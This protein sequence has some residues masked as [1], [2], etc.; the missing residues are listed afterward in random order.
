MRSERSRSEL[1]SETRNQKSES[2]L[3][4]SNRMRAKLETKDQKLRSE[5]RDRRK[6]KP[7]SETKNRKSESGLEPEDRTKARPTIRN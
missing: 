4:P 6:P 3:E 1:E 5:T 2:G 7:E